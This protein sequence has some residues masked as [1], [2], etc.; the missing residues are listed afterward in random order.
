M[1]HTFWP[2]T[3]KDDECFTNSELPPKDY[4]W[5]TI[6]SLEQSSKSSV[7]II[8]RSREGFVALATSRATFAMDITAPLL[9]FSGYHPDCHSSQSSAQS[10]EAL[11]QELFFKQK[12]ETPKMQ[13]S[14][15]WHALLHASQNA[16]TTKR[17]RKYG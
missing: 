14:A 8:R 7:A 16:S 6:Q 13:R 5:F 10:A 15:I 2:S 1:F 3:S 11:L 17:Q 4:E 9:F 12:W